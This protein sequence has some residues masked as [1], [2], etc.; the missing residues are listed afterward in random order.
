MPTDT[1][2]VKIVVER[3]LQDAQERLAF[4]AQGFIKTE[5]EGFK[6]RDRELEVL[7]RTEKLPMPNM[8][9]QTNMVPDLATANPMM[10]ML[11][12][13]PVSGGPDKIADDTSISRFESPVDALEKSLSFGKLV[14]AGT[15]YGYLLY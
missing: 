14:A 3:I 11:S 4:R 7:A 12:A 10:A 15:L 8:L 9:A 1:A 6:P 2:P 13:S 5:I